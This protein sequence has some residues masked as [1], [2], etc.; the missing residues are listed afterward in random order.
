MTISKSRL[1]QAVREARNEI[2]DTVKLQLADEHT[3]YKQIA[4]ANDI[5]TASVQRIAGRSGITRQVGPHSKA[6]GGGE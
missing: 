2:Y 6:S 3:T 5:S 4:E 1:L